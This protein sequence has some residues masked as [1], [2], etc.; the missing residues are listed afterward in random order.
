MHQSA[1]YKVPVP[2][3]NALQLLSA[4]TFE[5]PTPTGWRNHDKLME[6]LI[7]PKKRNF[8]IWRAVEGYNGF[9]PF[10][11]GQLKSLG[12]G[13]LVILTFKIGLLPRL[14]LLTCLSISLIGLLI[15]VLTNNIGFAFA[16]SFGIPYLLGL[17]AF[18][19]ESDKSKKVLMKILKT[20]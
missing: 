9:T 8:K 14:F 18:D 11:F 12:S 5:T 15:G 4:E 6:G 20:K 3:D 19:R 7:F 17:T 16:L 2:A 1:Q 10:M 13:T